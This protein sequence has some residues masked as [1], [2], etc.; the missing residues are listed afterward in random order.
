MFYMIYEY[1]TNQIK[2]AIQMEKYTTKCTLMYVCMF[3]FS[4]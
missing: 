2:F 1:T 3:L 4:L